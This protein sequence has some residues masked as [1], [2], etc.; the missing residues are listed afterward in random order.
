[1]ESCGMAVALVLAAMAAMLSAPAQGPRMVED[2]MWLVAASTQPEVVLA[3]GAIGEV[4]EW[5]LPPPSDAT[6]I[7]AAFGPGGR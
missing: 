6:G 5:K 1:M 2:V 3:A 4:E 7:V